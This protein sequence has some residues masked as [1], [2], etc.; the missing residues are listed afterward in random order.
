MAFEW[1]FRA[2][3]ASL[4][5]LDGEPIGLHYAGPTWEGLDGSRVMAAA[6]ANADSPDPSAIPWLLLEAQSNAGTGLFSTVSYIQRLDTSG[7]R[8]PADG[9]GASTVGQEARVPY[10]AIYTFSYPMASS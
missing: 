1:T 2:P 4:M 6:R 8:A 9:C 10:T 5:N 7:G 3:D